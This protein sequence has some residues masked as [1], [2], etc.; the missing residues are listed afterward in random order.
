M[1]NIFTDENQ[2]WEFD[3]SKAIWATDMLNEK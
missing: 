2:S 1:E 3:F